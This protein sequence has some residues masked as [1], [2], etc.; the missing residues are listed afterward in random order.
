M[1]FD[2][3]SNRI[4]QSYNFLSYIVS[5]VIRALSVVYVYFSLELVIESLA[6]EIHT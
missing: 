6:E 4:D 1:S 5:F 3:M 2:Y